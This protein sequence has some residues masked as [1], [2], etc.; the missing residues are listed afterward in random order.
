MT[1][2][3]F[4]EVSLEPLGRPRTVSGLLACE[5]IYVGAMCWY[6]SCEVP[7]CAPSHVLLVSISGE[8]R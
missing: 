7:V 4:G 6:G 2:E 8:I 1:L 3:I 5:D